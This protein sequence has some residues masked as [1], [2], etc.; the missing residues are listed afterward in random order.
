[1]RV[2]TR[3]GT[4]TTLHVTNGDSAGN[5]LRESGLPGVV[6]S[7]Q[8]V[9]HEG[10]LGNVDAAELR[11][12]RAS[13]LSDCGWG[14]RTAIQDDLERRDELFLDALRAGR[15]VVLWFEH[16]LFDQLQ[17]LQILALVAESEA[18]LEAIELL[19][20][21]D[22]PGR[23]DF[24]G[25]GEL[26]PH[27]L[28][29][30]WDRRRSLTPGIL[31]LG[32]SAWNILCGPDPRAIEAL[33]GRDTSALPYLAPAL[34]RLLEELPDTTSGLGRTERQALEAMAAGERTARQVF[35]ASGAREEAPFL[36]DGVMWLRL[37]ELGQGEHRLIETA[38]GTP[39]PDPRVVGDD[40]FGST[41]LV[42]TGA[43]RDVLAGT[44]DRVDAIGIDRWLGGT[45]LRPGDV[46]RWDRASG[47]VATVR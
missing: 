18:G 2:A 17:V 29:T 40:A 19:I 45:H 1:M 28:N 26:S 39:V 16:D 25:L 14:A 5:G 4:D 12:L 46:W 20:V 13:F 6:M 11:E 32:V 43:G 44:L 3:A 42:L 30:L 7:W 33:L 37:H 10:P 22:V 8:D 47:R 23:P 21:G 15:H 24:K 27:E 34:R 36:G 9:L 35:L 38:A 41:A 31:D